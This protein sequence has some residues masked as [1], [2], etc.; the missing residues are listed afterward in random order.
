[1]IL[2]HTQFSAI[3]VLILG[4]VCWGSW[5]N[6]YK[7]A[8]KW[9]Y[10]LYY[11]DWMFGAMVATVILALTAGSLGYDGFSFRDDLMIAG[12]RQWL[13]AF[14]AG[15]IFNFGNMLM[16]A[17]LSIA[18]LTVALPMAAGVGMIVGAGVSFAL[19]PS[20]QP[21]FLLLGCALMAGAVVA[22]AFVYRHML[23]LRHEKTARAGK[24]KSTRRPSST[25]ALVLAIA[26]GVLLGSFLS[27]LDLAR[28]GDIGLGPY[29]TSVLFVFGAL[30]STFIL[31]LFLMNLPVEGEPLEVFEYFHGSWKSHLYGL[32]GGAIW[33]AGLV[34]LLV[35]ATLPPPMR[36]G[37]V[38]VYGLSQ[39][40]PVLAALWGIVAW[41][42]LQ[43]GDGRV[44][45][46]AGL[47]LL[48][49]VGGIA[50]LGLAP[51]YVHR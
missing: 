25:K 8:D 41:K 16:V 31:N 1:M 38:A 29:S 24:A 4:L 14:L 5:A 44:T 39:G 51:L 30:A 42:E 12:K 26:S 9:R 32:A 2:P 7:L 10:E 45:V 46:F 13:W 22:A 40:W 11:F 43:G 36:P 23:V 47:Q 27:L 21:V 20:G 3:L 28:Q 19:A 49:L 37:P 15:V 6:T 35:V 33:S 17:C 50:L 34:A 18:G 48:L